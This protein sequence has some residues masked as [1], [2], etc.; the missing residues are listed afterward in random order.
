MRFGGRLLNAVTFLEKI[1]SKE[2][3]VLETEEIDRIEVV[4]EEINITETVTKDGNK[5]SVTESM[6]ITETV[7]KANIT[8]PF[9]WGVNGTANKGVW[10]KSEWA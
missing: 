6:T 7:S 4:S 2:E 10:N 9:K 1:A 8:P 5:R 3:V